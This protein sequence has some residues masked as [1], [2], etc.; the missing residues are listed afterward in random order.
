MA[1]NHLHRLRS[2]PLKT[3]EQQ[4]AL[5]RQMTSFARMVEGDV[6]MLSAKNI[7]WA[8]NAVKGFPG[9]EALFDASASRLCEVP[10]PE[11]SI[12][13]AALI[14]CAGM[15]VAAKR[16]LLIAVKQ[17]ILIAVCAILF[18]CY[19]IL[20]TQYLSLDACYLV[21]ITCYFLLIASRVR[22]S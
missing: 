9:Y 14:R 12:Q 1:L 15:L 6:G 16:L 3:A 21:R 4:E 2:D 8:L 10:P 20:I 22:H 5:E 11:W 18:T 13:S 17:Y 7:A 19:S